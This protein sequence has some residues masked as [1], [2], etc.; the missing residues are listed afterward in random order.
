[1]KRYAFLVLLTWGILPPPLS[2]QIATANKIESLGGRVTI[3]PA[4]KKIIAI[5]FSGS[6]KLDDDGLDFFQNKRHAFD[7]DLQGLI[8]FRQPI[9]DKGLL[10]L[11]DQTSLKVL[12]LT[13]TKITDAGLETLKGLTDLDTLSLS[14][15]NITDDGLPHLQELKNLKTLH[16]VDTPITDAG[17]EHLKGMTGLR[18]LD[19]SG[20]KTTKAGI[21]K[22]RKA[23][24]RT[25]IK[26]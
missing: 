9:T 23:L 25:S 18:L 12:L 13:Q 24:P 26:R 5:D 1:M 2:A 7:L 6:K 11:K 21:A 16:L 8:L 10:Y 20:S 3:N 17:L 22:L 19:L 4:R 15:T 14:L